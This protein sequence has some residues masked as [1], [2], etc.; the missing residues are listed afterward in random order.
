MAPFGALLSAC[1]EEDFDQSGWK[2]M[3]PHIA[4]IGNQPWRLLKSSL[5]LQK[6]CPNLS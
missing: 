6:S 2:Y 3:S 1:R 5:A 4:A